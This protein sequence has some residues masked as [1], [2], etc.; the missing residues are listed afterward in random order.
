MRKF[1]VSAALLASTI[2]VAA[3]AAAQWAPPVPQ[4]YAYGYNNNYGQVRR[5][6]ARVDQVRRTIRQLDRRNILSDREAR[7]LSNEAR[8]LDQ[9]INMLARNGFN[10]R[11]RQDIEIRLARLEQRIRRDAIDGN[12]YGYYGNNGYGQGGYD[13]DR[14]GRDDRYEDDRGRDHDGRRDRDR[15]NDD[16]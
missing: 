14:D 8:Y 7:R 2:A 9:R 5:L 10:R 1:L 3:P 4:G 13:R 11:D 15:D 6:E 16:D 12:R